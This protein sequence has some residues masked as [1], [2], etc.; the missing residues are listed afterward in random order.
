MRASNNKIVQE[1]IYILGLWEADGE[2]E[3]HLQQTL[4]EIPLEIKDTDSVDSLYGFGHDEN[5][6]WTFAGVKPKVE[7]SIVDEKTES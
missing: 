3:E 1:L 2:K 4:Q 7:E 5:K 6:K